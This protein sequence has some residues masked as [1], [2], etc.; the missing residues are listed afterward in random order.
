MA[1]V[2]SL[3]GIP[4]SRDRGTTRRR[5]VKAAYELFYRRGYARVSVDAIAERARITKRTLYDHFPSKDDV[6]AAMLEDQHDLATRQTGDWLD[7]LPVSP[8]AMADRLFAD[9]AA[10]A[11][12][13]RWSGSGFT[14][15]A[16]ELA[17]LPGHP[18]RAIARRHKAAVEER[19][20]AELLKRGISRPK[21][22][23]RALVLLIEGTNALMVIHGDR[24]YAAA[25]AQAARVLLGR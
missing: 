24:A 8:G 10:W 13:P 14:R 25:A 23:A 6:L 3:V 11:G 7:G 21:E 17:D 1:E 15:L 12:K 20:A 5:I 22:R 2:H 19:L 16:M 4:V 9:L 18:A